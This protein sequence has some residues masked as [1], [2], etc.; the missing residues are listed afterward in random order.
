VPNVAPQTND[1]TFTPPQ[2]IM[3]ST[4]ALQS[5]KNLFPPINAPLPLT[6]Q[7]SQK[8]LD[9]LKT[10]FRN[11][12]DR[13]HGP[14][15]DATAAPAMS[16]RSSRSSDE[17]HYRP[18][19]RHVQAILSNPLFSY[20]V[21]A[22]KSQKIKRDPMDVFDEA[23][24]KGMMTFQSAAGCLIAKREQIITSNSIIVRKPL[25]TPGAGLRVV[26]WLRSSGAED[27]MAFAQHPTLMRILTQFMVAEGL[28]IIAWEWVSR[29]LQSDNSKFANDSTAAARNLL[30]CI[31]ES[32]IK[33]SS[34]ESLDE[35]Y[36]TIV[37]AHAKFGSYQEL[38]PVFQTTWH[39][40]AWLSTVDA[41]RRPRPSE[42]LFD[43]FVNSAVVIKPENPQIPQ[44]HLGLHH[45]TQ[46][47]HERAL[48]YFEIIRDEHTLTSTQANYSKRIIAMG[49]DTISRLTQLG[50]DA[51]A[52]WILNLLQSK[53]ASYFGN[54]QLHPAG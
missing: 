30:R 29:L 48:R 24:A 54:R 15:H 19:D 38:D 45:P 52:Q 42:P 20:K 31:F 12:L 17:T 21:G 14:V 5:L 35:T 23:V 13:E 46:P 16:A 43:A 7:E 4:K 33:V 10:S 39:R 28:E 37:Q 1:S 11:N 8:L 53:Y 51:E 49:L 18:T 22:S 27:T 50:Q 40:L 36:G 25:A 9:A 32:N 2:D 44:A 26:Q 47:T 6:R 34:G 3:N 41:W